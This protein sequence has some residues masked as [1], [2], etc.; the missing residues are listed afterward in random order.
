MEDKKKYFCLPKDWKH[1]KCS[2][3]GIGSVTYFPVREYNEAVKGAEAA[4]QA[5]E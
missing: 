2:S 1:P 5:L 3:P 4:W